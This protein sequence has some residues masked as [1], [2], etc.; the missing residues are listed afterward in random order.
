RCGLSGALTQTAPPLFAEG[1]IMRRPKSGKDR[2]VLAAPDEADR[3]DRGHESEAEQRGRGKR[4]HHEDVL[5]VAAVGVGEGEHADVADARRAGVQRGLVPRPRLAAV[6]D[7]VL[8]QLVLEEP[9]GVLEL[10]R[11]RHAARTVAVVVAAES[12]GVP[13]GEE[14]G[15]L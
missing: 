15:G 14:P 1:P 13:R 8:G 3:R 4:N 9:E 2:V 7:L 12:A 11:G 5:V 10:A 6:A